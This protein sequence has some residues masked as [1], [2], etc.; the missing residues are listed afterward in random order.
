M[1][2][3]HTSIRFDKTH[4]SNLDHS[5]HGRASR[6][7][8][9]CRPCCRAE[10]SSST[11]ISTSAGKATAASPQT[12]TVAIPDLTGLTRIVKRIAE[13]RDV[14]SSNA[15]EENRDRTHSNNTALRIRLDAGRDREFLDSW[16][17][18]AAIGE[19]RPAAWNARPAP[20]RTRH[21]RDWFLA[22]AATARAL[23]RRS[24]PSRKPCSA[25]W[26]FQPGA[27]YVLVGSHLE[28]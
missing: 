24:G 4:H 17:E 20:P 23:H 14:H 11:V 3:T 19:T 28:G 8:A 25:C 6:S 15:P 2:P 26:S 13:A 18:L 1:T 16:A 5:T 22:V 9:V 12:R 10:P 21:V 7:T 27:P